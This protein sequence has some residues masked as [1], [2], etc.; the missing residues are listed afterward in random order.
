MVRRFVVDDPNFQGGV[1]V[2]N[3]GEPLPGE[4]P[5]FKES[6]FKEYTEMKIILAI[7]TSLGIKTD[8]TEQDI[9]IYAPLGSDGK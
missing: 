5:A 6:T 3:L 7:A 9:R 2:E 8:Y 4:H 1:V